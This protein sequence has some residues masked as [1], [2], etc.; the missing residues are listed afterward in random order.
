MISIFLLSFIASSCATKPGQ[1]FLDPFMDKLSDSK[2]QHQMN[3]NAFH[4]GQS[5]IQAGNAA[6]DAGNAASMHQMHHTPPPAGF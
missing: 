6:M 3:N 5:A 1:G 4:S 2:N